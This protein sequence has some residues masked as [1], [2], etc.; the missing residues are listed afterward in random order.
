MNSLRIS[1]LSILALGLM[2]LSLLAPIEAVWAGGSQRPDRQTVPHTRTPR[3]TATRT[4][5]TPTPTPQVPATP[6]AAQPGNPP[7][8][9]ATATSTATASASPT[10][11]TAPQAS[12]TGSATIA[13]TSPPTATQTMAAAEGTIPS[14]L[15]RQPAIETRAAGDAGEGSLPVA[16]I[17]PLEVIPAS[18]SLLSCG[19]G[20]VGLLLV[21]IGIALTRRR[22]L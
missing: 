4:A 8:A 6:T 10:A 20:V 9:P 3:P 15:T 21:T 14:V 1:I 18:S 2:C 13:S 12:P 7:P 22:G 16:T 11:A 17:P 5:I 19:V